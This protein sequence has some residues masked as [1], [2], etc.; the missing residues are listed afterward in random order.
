MDNFSQA[1]LETHKS[2]LVKKTTT[3]FAVDYADD[4]SQKLPPIYTT[5]EYDCELVYSDLLQRLMVLINNIRS[6][7]GLWREHSKLI[8]HLVKTIH[9]FYMP[10]IHQV[11]VPMLIEFTHKGNK[12]TKEA[13]C[14]CL[15]IIL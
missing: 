9:L 1:F 13:S 4:D 3:S 5:E 15:A 14:H 2:K 12:E 6:Y 7:S 11:I 8:N 10:E